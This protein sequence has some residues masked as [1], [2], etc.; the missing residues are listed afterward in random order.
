MRWASWL[1]LFDLPEV[2]SRWELFRVMSPATVSSQQLQ[3]GGGA[4]FCRST[5]LTP[6]WSEL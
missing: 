5:F 3:H 2:S 1:R 6:A 4:E